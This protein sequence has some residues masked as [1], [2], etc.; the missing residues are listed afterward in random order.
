M[1]KTFDVTIRVVAFDT[2]AEELRDRVEETVRTHP[3][4]S[5]RFETIAV[6][7]GVGVVGILGIARVGP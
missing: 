6:H 2:T 1:V 5:F 3:T 4:L 7:P